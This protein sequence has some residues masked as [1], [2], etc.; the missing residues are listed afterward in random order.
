M[1]TLR[2][3]EKYM[4]VKEYMEEN[5][6]EIEDLLESVNYKK[7]SITVTCEGITKKFYSLCYKYMG[8]LL[9]MVYYAYSK[10]SETIRKRKCGTK[11]FYL[12][13]E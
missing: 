6:V 4:M 13:W 5:N 11:V 12:R 3:L 1:L 9:P 10:K 8:V 7:I 2:D